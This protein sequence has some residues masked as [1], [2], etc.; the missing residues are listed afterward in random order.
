VVVTERRHRSIGAGLGYRTD[1]RLLARLTWEHRNIFHGAERLSLAAKASGFTKSVE[2]GFKKPYFLR[3]DQSLRLSF[4][5]AEDEPDAYM[6]RNL[7]A[8][9]V[10]DRNLTGEIKVG[11]GLAFKLSEVEQL[12]EEENFRLLSLPS[13]LEWD[14][15]DRLLD[16]TTGG[17]LALLLAPYYD[18]S[19]LEFGF[20]KTQISGTQYLQVFQAPRL[21]LAGRLG[22]GSL[23]ATDLFSVPAD[24]RFYAGGGGSIRGYA[25]QSAG[26]L[27]D[28]QPIGGRSL[29]EVSFEIRS[30]LTSRWGLV[31][32]LD[33][34]HAFEST[35]P[36]F[37]EPLL[38]GAG[39]GFRYFTPVGPLRFD[40]A[41]PLNRRPE[42]DE[43]FQIYVSLGQSF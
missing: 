15:T 12:Q 11:A 36:D 32:F 4:R 37:S 34:G 28:G 27:V 14:S 23:T 29:F 1:E 3:E 16:P 10:L 5:M 2:V 24:E 13:Y 40:V 43:H 42:I 26:P 21:V 41:I 33:G 20:F 18:V 30:E 35:V 25:Y 38:W 17:R 6:S 31:A 9:G 19:G 39:A 7:S 22:L 8:S